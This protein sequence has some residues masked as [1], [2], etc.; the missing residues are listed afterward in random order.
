MHCA[1]AKNF[2]S[3]AIRD[4][5]LDVQTTPMF[6]RLLP[7]FAHGAPPQTLAAVAQEQDR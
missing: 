2:L 1:I 6:R 4:A 3:G 5:H 7:K